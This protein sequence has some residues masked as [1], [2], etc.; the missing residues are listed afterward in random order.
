MKKVVEQLINNNIRSTC[1]ND[2]LLHLCVS[3]LNVI[4]SGYFSDG[5]SLVVSYNRIHV[6]DFNCFFLKKKIIY[7][8]NSTVFSQIY[9]C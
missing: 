7:L 6:Y 5:T 3:R 4:K 8:F 9:Q 1:T 2:T